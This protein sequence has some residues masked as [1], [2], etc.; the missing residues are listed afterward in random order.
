MSNHMSVKDYFVE[1][2]K[3]MEVSDIRLVLPPNIIYDVEKGFNKDILKSIGATQKE[4]PNCTCCD[5]CNVTCRCIGDWQIETAI[6]VVD[7]GK[8][9]AL[10]WRTSEKN[11]NGEVYPIPAEVF[12]KNY[13]KVNLNSCE[14][15]KYLDEGCSRNY[16]LC[17]DSSQP[18][19]TNPKNYINTFDELCYPVQEYMLLHNP[20]YHSCKNFVKKEVKGNE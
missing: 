3:T 12:E 10:V 7:I 19:C 16:V 5:D 13:K 9:C 14:K 18:V 15:C 4:C 1:Y 8:G 20:T 11:P 6:G 17:P 2:G